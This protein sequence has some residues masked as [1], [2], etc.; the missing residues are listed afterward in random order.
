M[1]EIQITAL[2]SR[3]QIVIPQSIRDRLC[4]KEG[5]RFA[6]A[7]SNNTIV[8]KKIDM[9]TKEQLICELDKIAKEGRKRLEAKGIRNEQDIV[10]LIHKNRAIKNAKKN[11]V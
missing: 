2:S 6:I 8:L 3:G 1:E 9:P 11:S 10:D 7:G 4:L 5:E